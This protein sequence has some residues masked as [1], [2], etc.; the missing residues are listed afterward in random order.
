MKVFSLELDEQ[1][2]EVKLSGKGSSANIKYMLMPKINSDGD[3]DWTSYKDEIVNV[4]NVIIYI[5]IKCDLLQHEL[6]KISDAIAEITAEKF[7]PLIS[8]SR[9]LVGIRNKVIA[10]VVGNAQTTGDG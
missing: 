4:I 9:S 2:K 8:T 7:E 3:Y 1:V 10:D 6:E 5:E